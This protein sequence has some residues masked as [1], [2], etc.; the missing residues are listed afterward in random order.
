MF[1]TKIAIL[2]WCCLI[3]LFWNSGIRAAEEINR[4]ELECLKGAPYIF[5]VNID[6]K[7][8]AK[9]AKTI[10]AQDKKREEVI[11][12]GIEKWKWPGGAR[13]LLVYRY[14]GEN[15]LTKSGTYRIKNDRYI[16]IEAMAFVDFNDLISGKNLNRIVPPLTK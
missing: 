16:R 6:A 12:S 3:F 8:N 11:V 9:V 10:R 4:G 7:G 13:S 1:K 15:A 5:V 14:E 2:V